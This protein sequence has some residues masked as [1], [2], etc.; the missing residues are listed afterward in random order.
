MDLCRRLGI[1]PCG[2]TWVRRLSVVEDG[3]AGELRVDATDLALLRWIPD[4]VI[5]AVSELVVGLSSRGREEWTSGD[6]D[7]ARIV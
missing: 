2:D 3:D 7:E 4:L 6:V 1:T 5:T